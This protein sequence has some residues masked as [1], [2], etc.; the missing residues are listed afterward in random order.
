M[1]KREIIVYFVA[2]VCG[3]AVSANPPQADGCDANDFAAEVVS[4]YAGDGASYYT[5]PGTALG[6]PAVDT[7]YWG[8]DRPVVPVYPQWLPT[9]IV[10]V[11]VGGH[12]ILKFNH[13]ICDDRNN[14]YGYDFIVFGN[15]LFSIGGNWDY[16]DPCN[17]FISSGQVNAEKGKVSVSQDGV[18]WFSFDDGPWADSF[19]PTLRRVFDPNEPAYYPGWENLWWGEETNPTLPLDPNVDPNDF[20]G[21][22]LA[23]V[24][25]VYGKSA[26]GTAF[27][28]RRLADFNNLAI[29]P[30]SGER[31]I[32]YVMIECLGTDPGLG[33][34]KPEVDAVSDV[35]CC[36]DYKH[37]FPAGDINRDCVVGFEDLEIMCRNWLKSVG[38]EEGEE[39]MADLYKDSDD[40]INFRDFA[41]LAGDWLGRTWP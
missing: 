18:N 7:D 41:V 9:E 14:P 34:P 21:K 27:D 24:C 3:V 8:A 37:P 20:A 39:W 4:Y 25:L 40:I 31:W 32:Q 6:E 16:G 30:Q 28:L 1:R 35:S 5:F 10:T 13:K 22:S 15:S 36:G 23:E 12:L 29:D 11:G 2:V 26:G 17:C 19:A 38:D 33:G